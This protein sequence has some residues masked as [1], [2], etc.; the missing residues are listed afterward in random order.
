MGRRRGREDD[1]WSREEWGRS[2]GEGKRIVGEEE[3]WSG[4]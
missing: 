2:G 1:R 4:R 3:S